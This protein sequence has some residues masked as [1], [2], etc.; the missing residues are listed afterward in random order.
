[1]ADIIMAA[2]VQVFAVRLQSFC[3]QCFLL[4]GLSL[5]P[6]ESEAIVI[7]TGVRQRSE[8]SLDVVA[9]VA[10]AKIHPQDSV[11]SFGIIIAIRCLS[12]CISAVCE[13]AHFHTRALSHIRKCMWE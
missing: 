7:G 4:N 11:K 6:D 3:T 9:L 8:G 12:M 5:N 10:D 13:A 2:M 1:M